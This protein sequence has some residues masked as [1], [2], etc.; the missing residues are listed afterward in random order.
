MP[1]SLIPI[2]PSRHHATVRCRERIPSTK[3]A[4][5]VAT[6][7]RHERAWHTRI[8][9]YTTVYSN[10]ESTL[11]NFSD[12][13]EK[14]EIVA[15]KAYLRQ[16]IANFA[17]LA[18]GSGSGSRGGEDLEKNFPVA[19]P[20]IQRPFQ[21]SQN[22]WVIVARNGQNKAR[23]TPNSNT[24]ITPMS[25]IRPR[26]SNKEKSPATPTDKRLFLQL[27]QEHEWRKFSPAGIREV[28]VKKLSISPTLI[29]RI[30]PVHSGFA[31]SPCST[32]AWEKILNAGN[33]LFLT[34]AK[35]EAATNRA[36]HLLTNRAG[37]TLDLAWSNINNIMAWVGTEGYIT[38]GH[39]PICGFVPVMGLEPS[40]LPTSLCIYD[41]AELVTVPNHKASAPKLTASGVKFRVSKAN[42]L[43]FIRVVLHWL[44]Q[45]TIINTVEETESYAQGICWALD[46]AMKAVGKRPNQKSGRSAYQ[47][48]M[49]GSK[50][51]SQA[52]KFRA[53]VASAKRTHWKKKVEDMKTAQETFR[54]M[55]WASSHQVERARILRDS[56][57]ARFSASDD[58]PPFSLSRDA[59][60]PWLEELTE[61]EVR[62]CTIGSG[63][64]GPGADRISV[65]LLA[66]CLQL[67]VTQ[68]FRA[69]LRLGYHPKCFKLAKVGF[70]PKNGQDPSSAKGWRPILLLSCLVKVGHQQ[71]EALPKRLA[72]GLV[73]CVVHD[74]EE[75]KSQGRASTF[76]TLDMQG[77]FNAVILNRLIWRMQNQG[78]PKVIL[79]W[80]TSFL[81]N[82]KAQV[83]FLGGVT[84]PKKLPMRSGNTIACFSYADDV[85][86]FGFGPT[87]SESAAAVHRE[88]EEN[89]VFF[90][91]KKSEVIHFPWRK[92]GDPIGTTVIGNMINPAEQ[93]R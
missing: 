88:A 22:A 39:L 27:P 11:A 66:T 32:E 52:M 86:I 2:A 31:L 62:A 64:T 93:I 50:R 85:G 82:R 90:D 21:T 9:V 14:E 10:I 84:D 83:R 20:Q 41:Q 8:I 47:E 40:D 13:I 68:L 55:R 46:S 77:A 49:N 79:R 15:F 48:A 89:A 92:K 12:E 75:A 61:L 45:P 87:I 59:H 91:A 54:L 70:L 81:K 30:K 60:N 73:T 1:N 38:I 42:V 19:I 69:C 29:G 57:L 5:I 72:N 58:P 65:E 43:Q 25:K 36:T 34:G 3:L 76:V 23:V 7:Q 63:N 35:L 6:R 18:K 78:W 80:A 26:R 71:F 16:A 17:A 74:I 24:H 4:E 28:I 56:L 67:D 33:G 44:P 51:I 53:T 37:N